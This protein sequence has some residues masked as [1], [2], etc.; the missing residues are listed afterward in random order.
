MGWSP[1]RFGRFI[2]GKDSVQE[3]KW[4]RRPMWTGV[5]DLAPPPAGI[6][7]PDRPTR[8]SRYNDWTTPARTQ[9]YR[10]LKY[11]VGCCRLDF[12][13]RS[14]TPLRV[15]GNR[16]IK[17]TIERIDKHRCK[18]FPFEIHLGHRVQQHVHKRYKTVRNTNRQ[19]TSCTFAL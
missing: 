6:R 19:K 8:S 1:P 7:S 5:E 16:Q 9:T 4:A 2:H 18:S 10:I 12:G 13:N 17:L 3:A 15:M 11:V 14:Y